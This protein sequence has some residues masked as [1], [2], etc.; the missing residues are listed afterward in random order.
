MVHDGSMAAFVL[1]RPP[2]VADVM[3]AAGR[4]RAAN[5]EMREL[6]AEA[7]GP[8]LGEVLIQI[9]EAGIDPLEAV[10]ADGLRRFDT[11]GEYAEDGALR[12]VD[13]LRPPGARRRP[14]DQEMR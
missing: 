3:A 11:A 6:A 4:L 2:T 7:E 9:R 14:R 8:V 5:N 10:F 1:R 13:W 12:T